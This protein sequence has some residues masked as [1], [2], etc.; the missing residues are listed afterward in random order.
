M[1][2]R[3]DALAQRF[4]NDPDVVLRARISRSLAGRLA[5]ARG[6]EAM[7]ADPGPGQQGAGRIGWR[8]IPLQLPDDLSERAERLRPILGRPVKTDLSTV[9]LEAIEQG[10]RHM[11]RKARG[12]QGDA[13]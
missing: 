3:L 6:I 4:A 2:A 11:E 9:L 5:L 10:L 7:E 12:Q 13:S 1:L 8:M